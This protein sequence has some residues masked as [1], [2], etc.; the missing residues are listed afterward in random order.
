[1]MTAPSP[2]ELRQALL[3]PRSVALIGA[4]GDPAKLTARPQIFLRQHGFQGH[5]FPV[6]PGRETVLGAPAFARVTDI[7]E[8]VDHAHIMLDADPA[9]DALDD[10]AAA[11]VTVVSILADGFAEAGG[12]GRARQKRLLDTAAAGGLT[13]IGPN[14]MGVVDTRSGFACTTNAAF[15]VDKLAKGR[16]AVISQSGSIIGT[17]L[18]RGQARG[19]AYSIL[20][21]VGNEAQ[22]GVGEIGNLIVEDPGTD[23]FLLFLETLR[24]ADQI[25]SFARRAHELGKPVIAYFVGRSAEGQALSVSHTGA[26]TGSF[27]AAR[28]FLGHHG[29]AVVDF[30]EALIESPAALHQT[31]SFSAR[32]RSATVVSTTGGG[33]A[34]LVDQI[35]ARGVAISGAPEGARRDLEGQGVKLGKGKLIDLTLAGTNY[36]TVHRVLSA[37][38]KSPETGAVIAAI[39]SSAEFNPELSINPII[40]AHKDAGP[41][42]APLLAFLLPEAAESLRLL[43]AAGVPA[44]RTVE[45]CADT[46]ALILKQRPPA[47]DGATRLPAAVTG[48]LRTDVPCVLNEIDSMAVFRKL[49]VKG[50]KQIFLAGD[51]ALPEELPFAYPCVVK[52]V[53]ADLPHKTDVGALRLAIADRAALI[54]AIQEMKTSVRAQRPDAAIE[55]VLIQETC[56]GVGEVLAGLGRDPLAGPVMT[57]GVGGVLTEI[58]HDIAIRPAPLTAGTAAE[59]IEEVNGFALLRGFR[60]RPEGDFDALA[61]AVAAISALALAPAVIEAEINPLSVGRKGEGVTMLDALIRLAP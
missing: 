13:V 56:R 47:P 6:N 53:S 43:N 10:C 15:A 50:P 23:G 59:M 14:C 8:Q 22:I 9:L 39:G 27:A 31:R 29:I 3:R 37:L 19:K 2:E 5:V 21:S 17:V 42:A 18:S 25:A 48:L 16:Y 11:G 24:R 54:A 35:S 28:S 36:D 26:M 57:I 40:D 38:I 1:M 33:G 60:G 41:G 46:V 30:F 7:P 44:F 61:E 32:P 58:Y 55:G 4:S 51:E 34:M 12:T 49:G 20:I 52:L 45:S